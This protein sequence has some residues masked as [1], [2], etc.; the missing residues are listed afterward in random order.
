MINRFIFGFIPYYFHKFT[1]QTSPNIRYYKY[2]MNH[3]YTHHL[4]EFRD[5]YANINT[6]V[7]QDENNGLLYILSDHKRLY[8]KRGILPEKINRLYK[9]LLMEQDI[10]SPHHYLE[11]IQEIKGKVFV[12]AGCAEGFTSLS[13]VEEASHIYLFESDESWI[14]ALK[15]TFSPWCDKVTIVKRIVG[16]ENNETTQTLDNFFKDKSYDNLFLKMDIEG[17]E[18]DALN[19]CREMFSKG[20]NLRFA[21]CTYHLEDDETV[22]GA[23]LR[24]H[25]CSYTNQKGFFRHKLRSVVLRGGK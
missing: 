10:R 7:R 2:I 18:R 19:G 12:D 8:F 14:E 11:N 23:F 13:V 24:E 20:Q 4:Y 21:I 3:G 16:K 5:E 22:I 9:A 1:N 17:S 15:A 25:G 6:E